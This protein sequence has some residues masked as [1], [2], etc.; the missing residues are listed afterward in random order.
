MGDVKMKRDRLRG[1][2][3][4]RCPDLDIEDD[5]IKQLV[6][7]GFNEYAIEGASEDVLTEVLP[8]RLGVVVGL[9]KTFG[10]PQLPAGIRL[11][12]RRKCDFDFSILDNWKSGVV[13]DT[14]I[15]GVVL[16][17]AVIADALE[18]FGGF[19]RRYYVRHEETMVFQNCINSLKNQ[20]KLRALI[21][22]SPGVGKSVFLVL[23]AFYLAHVESKSV[24]ILRK[25]QEA[26][27]VG[28]ACV[29]VS[30][31]GSA[32]SRFR[33]LA[34]Y[35]GIESSLPS[36]GSNQEETLLFLDGFHQD[37]IANVS[38]HGFLGGFNLLATSSQYRIRSVDGATRSILLPAWR[39]EDLR[40]YAGRMEIFPEEEF[41][42]RFQCA[43]SYSGGS[44]REF[45][46]DDKERENLFRTAMNCI[47]GDSVHTLL[48]KYGA[49]SNVQVD[50]I[51][52]LYVTDRFNVEHYVTISEYIPTVD[53]T[54][55]LGE[56]RDMFTEE[57]FQSILTAGQ[58]I[59]GAFLGLAYPSSR[60]NGSSV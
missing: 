21:L 44:L 22:G 32:G 13:P 5:D 14:P 55:A 43:Y 3:K 51:R 40:L 23:F 28:Y 26:G 30:E 57:E 48:S 27:Q 41:E 46:R 2:L 10:E 24:I 52:K 50:T 60:Y 37:D 18:K 59:G 42:E 4:R 39:S 20:S 7:Q 12:E 19:P 8:G 54:V 58:S 36:D 53:S 1:F 35:R 56:L 17:T 15:T 45:L 38:V 47:V 9:V 49:G 33:D 11:S 16:N 34:E 31:K 25:L 6:A 29:H